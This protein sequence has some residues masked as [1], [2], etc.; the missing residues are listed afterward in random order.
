MMYAIDAE[1]AENARVSRLV[2]EKTRRMTP[3]QAFE[4]AV[5]VGIYHPDGTLTAEYGG[6]GCEELDSAHYSHGPGS[7]R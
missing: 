5:S 4:L 7:Q 1:R 3:E 2:L 6:P